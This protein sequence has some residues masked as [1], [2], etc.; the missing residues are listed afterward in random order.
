MDLETFLQE[1]VCFINEANGSRRQEALQESAERIMHA[2]VILKREGDFYQ[3]LED[4]LRGDGELYVLVLSTIYY[5]TLDS[6]CLDVVEDLILAGEFDLFTSSDLCFQLANIR[7][8]DEK[9][10]IDYGRRRQ[11]QRSLLER[12]EKEYPVTP[13]Y[14]PYAKR[15]Q[16]RIV[17]ETDCVLGYYHAPTRIVMELCYLLQEKLGY[18]VFLLVN[19]LE[20][21]RERME[22]F[23]LF[24]YVRNYKKDLDGSFALS[25]QGCEITGY[26]LSVGTGNLEELREVLSR[27]GEW[28]PM[29]VWHI[30]GS[31][32]LHDIY[33]GMTTVLSMACTDGY[34]I[35]EAPVLTSFMQSDSEAVNHQI[36]M[37]QQNGQKMVN[38]QLEIEYDGAGR[39]YRKTEFGFDG[40]AFVLCVAGNR[41]DDEMTPSF[42][43][44]LERA[45]SKDE[46]I[47]IAVIGDCKKTLLSGIPSDRVKFLGFRT[48]LV[49]VIRMTDLFVNPPRKGGGGGAA[50]SIAAGVPV[51]TMPYCDVANMVDGDFFVEDLEQME[52][53][54]HR[55]RTDREYYKQQQSR[56]QAIQNQKSGNNNAENVKK[57]MDQVQTWLESG[58]IR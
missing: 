10:H 17:V 14:I 12:F 3:E 50:R 9:L 56:I 15:C 53:A 23:W 43:E 16:S 2:Y 54:I 40:D 48:D 34:S 57:I 58:E 22:Q 42:V 21:K 4:A 36:E 39:I 8:R 33:R 45:A 18:E 27:I 30:G 37:I 7:F 49:D 24:P 52:Q 11:I 32:F 20:M 44:M 29:C 26:Q 19:M 41:L 28:K 46:R 13:E 5:V 31:G 51:V 25:Y 6:R 47:G 38:F 55:Y 1:I 35:S